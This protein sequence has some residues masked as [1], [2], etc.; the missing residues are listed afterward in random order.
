[1]FA[2]ISFRPPSR[3]WALPV[4]ESSLFLLSERDEGRRVGGAGAGWWLGTVRGQVSARGAA[5]LCLLLARWGRLQSRVQRIVVNVGTWSHGLGGALA[6]RETFRKLLPGVTALL[7]HVD[8]TCGGR[9][10]SRSA[11]CSGNF[12][13]APLAPGLMA[14]RRVGDTGTQIGPSGAGVQSR[15]RGTCLPQLLVP[16]LLGPHSALPHHCPVPSLLP[17]SNSLRDPEGLIF[18]LGSVSSLRAKGCLAWPRGSP[19]PSPRLARAGGTPT[20]G[21]SPLAAP[22]GRGPRGPGQPSCQLA[23]V[24]SC[25]KLGIG[26]SSRTGLRK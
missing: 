21:I 12:V 23:P 2:G 20:A 13:Q 19:V 11:A 7:S 24:R 4:E 8:C 9:T 25:H 14:G 22:F 18:L 26:S 6:V 16:S 17:Q 5:A 1:M 3:S 10:V 15:P